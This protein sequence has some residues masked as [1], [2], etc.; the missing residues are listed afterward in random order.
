MGVVH[1][2]EMERMY[3]T[4]DGQ[5][6]TGMAIEPPKK[7]VQMTNGIK[8]MRGRREIGRASCRERV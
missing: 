4:C 6:G 2:I 7:E 5:R 8:G 3:E 1:N